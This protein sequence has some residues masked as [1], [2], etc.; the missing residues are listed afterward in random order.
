[1]GTSRAAPVGLAGGRAASRGRGGQGPPQA[2]RVGQ[3][4]HGVG[5]TP[6]VEAVARRQAPVVSVPAPAAADEGPR[7]ASVAGQPGIAPRTLEA[8]A[9]RQGAAR[10]VRLPDRKSAAVDTGGTRTGPT[11]RDVA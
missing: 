2:Q 1:M 11:V 9:L 3:T 7:P 6:P 4:P 10:G 8:A 5:P